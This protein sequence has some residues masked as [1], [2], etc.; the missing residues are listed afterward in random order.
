MHEIAVYDKCS[1]QQRGKVERSLKVIMLFFSRSSL[2]WSMSSARCRWE[3]C[4]FSRETSSKSVKGILLITFRKCLHFFHLSW[5]LELCTRFVSSAAVRSMATLEMMWV[6]EWGK[7]VKLAQATVHLWALI[8]F[9]SKTLLVY[10][11]GNNFRCIFP[12]TSGLVKQVHSAH[13]VDV[14]SLQEKKHNAAV[15]GDHFLLYCE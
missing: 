4:G 3:R 6:L 5:I 13:F 10:G 11:A 8:K 9:R 15:L 12:A 2:V 1:S 14:S 7:R